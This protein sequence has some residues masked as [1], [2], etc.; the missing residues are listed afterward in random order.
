MAEKILSQ[1]EVEALL[2]G[3]QGGEVET[4]SGGNSGGA[5]LYDFANQERIVRGRM[6]SLEIINERFARYFQASMINF[7]KK[8]IEVIP[9]SID[10][11]RFGAL[12]L[13]IPLPSSINII[14][15]NPLRGSNLVVLDTK[16]VYRLV[17]LYFGGSGQTYVKIEGRNFTLIEH[18]VIK[19]VVDKI[20]SDLEKA[21]KPVFPIAIS[22]TRTE[23]NPQFATIVAPTEVVITSQFKIE[24]DGEGG[25]IF[26][27][28]PY[29]NIEPIREKLYGGFQSNQDEVNKIWSERFREQLLESPLKVVAKIGASNITVRE[30]SRLAV[31]DVIMLDKTVTEDLDFKVEGKTVFHGK[32]GLHQGSVAFQVTSLSKELNK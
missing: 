22:Y 25:D 9:K 20:L 10:V 8:D 26:V 30:V 17:E 18:R 15:M 3:V 5:Q 4:E 16:F 13:K 11:P 28:M 31:G 7:L 2:K 23:I 1:D 32:P 12:M 19:K 27:G 24:I 6:P 29:T 14:T 21:W